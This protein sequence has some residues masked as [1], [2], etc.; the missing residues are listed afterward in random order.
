M[1][2]SLVGIMAAVVV[3]LLALER[4]IKESR[5]FVVELLQARPMIRLRITNSNTHRTKWLSG[6]GGRNSQAEFRI[7]ADELRLPVELRPEE[8]VIV[9][10][11]PSALIRGHLRW[12]GVWDSTGRVTKLRHREMRAILDS[13]LTLPGRAHLI[14]S[15]SD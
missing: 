6:V 10:A 5:G 8:S 11:D 9:A 3:A 4:R 2:L 15:G 7:E 13:G 14:R 1:T 12:I